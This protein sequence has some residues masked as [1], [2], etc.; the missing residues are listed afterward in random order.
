MT[1]VDDSARL[2][3]LIEVWQ[4]AVSDAVA[5]L[6]E[7]DAADWS[8]P[9]DLPG[10]DVRAVAAHLAH[11]ESELA[12]NP[13]T[14]VEVAEAP[15]I[16][17]LMGQFTERGPLARADWPTT[18]IVDELERSAAQRRAALEADP[19]TDAGGLAPGFAGAIGWTWQTLLT[20]RPLDVWV[21]EQDIRRA[22]GRPGN[23]DTAGARHTGEVFAGAL[24]FVV[25]KKA[26]AA[27]GTTVALSI[28]G[29]PYADAPRTLT[30]T[31]ADDGR[32]HGLDDEPASTDARIELSFEDWVVLA[33]GRRDRSAVHATIDG[34]STLAERVLSHLVV[35]P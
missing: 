7:L 29:G 6:R 18:R 15:H 24:P 22:V 12:G 25:G 19:P 28:S 16:K 11:L 21:H 20:N 13:Q 1:P 30:V 23:L 5:L 26:G 33:G 2:R 4:S 35:T 31:V 9:T 14:D 10:W 3:R 34:D 8:L 17:G 27:P 32:A